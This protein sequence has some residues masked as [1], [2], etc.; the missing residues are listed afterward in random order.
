[1]D[2]NATHKLGR[3]VIRL[4]VSLPYVVMYALAP[5][6]GGAHLASVAALALVAGGLWGVTRMRVWGLAALAGAAI[7]MV[8]DLAGGGAVLSAP[9]RG[10]LSIELAATGLTAVV[11]L[12][13]AVAP[14]AAPALRYLRGRSA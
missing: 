9:L 10:G 4:G 8:A 6:Q 5:R 11:L 1:M 14:F 12:A 3:S 13:G 2:E 7:I